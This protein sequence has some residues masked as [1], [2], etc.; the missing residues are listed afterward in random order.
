MPSATA[1]SIAAKGR[2]I[3]TMAPGQARALR[4]WLASIA[5][6]IVAMIFVGGLP[7]VRPPIRERRTAAIRR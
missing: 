5:F 1:P 4:L 6:L 2:I 7:R 3:T